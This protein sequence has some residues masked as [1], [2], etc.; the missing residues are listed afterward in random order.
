MELFLQFM[1]GALLGLSITTAFSYLVSDQ[2]I[3]TSSEPFLQ[4]MIKLR[5]FKFSD[6]DKVIAV[7]YL[8]YGI[9]LVFLFSYDFLFNQTADISW[10]MALGFGGIS[11]IV[12]I[13]GWLIIFNAPFRKLNLPV[14]S[15]FVLLF[16]A[17]FLFAVGVLAVYKHVDLVL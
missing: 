15:C 6:G 13:I 8:L 1:F 7:W 2:F 12:A 10:R 5:S 3:A 4:Y 11:G 17:H 9:S 16:L 14:A